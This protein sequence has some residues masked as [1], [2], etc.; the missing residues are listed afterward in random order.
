MRCPPGY[1][2][3][4][5]QMSDSDEE[6]G[7]GPACPVSRRRHWSEADRLRIVAES[8]QSGVS[9][10]LVAR[11]NDVN[12]NLLFTCRDYEKISQPP[13]PFHAMPRG[14]ESAQ[15]H[16]PWQAVMV[17]LRLGPWRRGPARRA[18][19]VHPDRHCQAQR[20]RPAGLARRCSGTHP[21]NPA[22][23]ARRT[24]SVEL[25]VRGAALSGH[26]DRDLRKAFHRP[27]HPAAKLSAKC[28]A[29]FSGS[30]LCG[31]GMS[32]QSLR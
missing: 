24:P 22:E 19:D 7:I 9:V 8:Y 12:A 27:Y 18:A 20:C 21:G 15:R 28:P 30:L 25:V 11:R 23:P 10:S 14:R 26:P 1:K 3:T 17:V 5:S 6:F 4:R 2:W 31:S 16:C 32:R 29:V 13:A